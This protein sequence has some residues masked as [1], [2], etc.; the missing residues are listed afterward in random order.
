MAEGLIILLGTAF[1]VQVLVSRLTPPEK[2]ETLK[3]FYVKCKPPGLWKPVADSLGVEHKIVSKSMFLQSTTGIL[4]CLGFVIATN[5]IFFG[6]IEFIAGGV[7]L[8]VISGY[9]LLKS[10]N[11]NKLSNKTD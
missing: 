9:F 10:I 6:G 5:A 1:I 11:K 8:S 4:T 7:S 2:M 3:A